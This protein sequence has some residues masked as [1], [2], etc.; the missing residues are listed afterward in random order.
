VSERR[1][2]GDRH[3][4][5]VITLPSDTEYLV[6]RAFDAPAQLV[7]EAMTR[8]E[9]VQ[10]WW[11][12]ETAAWVRCDIDLRVGGAWRYVTTDRGMEVAFHGTFLEIDAPHRLVYTEMFEGMPV[13]PPPEAYPVNTMV[14]DEVDGVTTMTVLVRHTTREERDMVL[15]TGMEG[16]MQASYDRL[17][18]LIRPA[19]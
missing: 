5:A 17:Q 9:L 10:R 18:D 19:G 8:P 14:L 7:F 13:L 3:G 4:S 16:G 11:G 12:Y 15:A 2:I 1:T 6:T